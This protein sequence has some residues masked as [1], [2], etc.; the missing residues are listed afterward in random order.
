MAAICKQNLLLSGPY[1]GE[2]CLEMSKTSR[3]TTSRNEL[4][5][6][7]IE[8][9]FY[10][11]VV[12][13][14]AGELFSRDDVLEESFQSDV[15][16]SE[17]DKPRFERKF[18]RA[19]DNPVMMSGEYLWATDR[20]SYFYFHWLC[21]VLPRLEA[22]FAKG[23]RDPPPLVIPQRIVGQPFVHASLAAWP[24]ILVAPPRTER[25]SVKPEWLEAISRPAEM[26]FVHGALLRAVSRRLKTLASSSGK[27]T[28]RVYVTRVSARVRRVENEHEIIPVLQRHGFEIVEMEKLALRQQIALMGETAVLAGPHGGG[29]TNMM[30]MPTGGNVLELRKGEGPPPCFSNLAAAFGHEWLPFVCEAQ[31]DAEHPHAAHIL[32]DPEKFDDTLARLTTK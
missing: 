26:P 12:F 29:L 5:I 13:N 24:E 31:D 14:E 27:A 16:F 32:A 15:A 1:V 8:L 22:F 18:R 4:L 10:Q 17:R 6:E 11:N 2:E 20:L 19:W 7:P 23:R 30:F 3:E 9:R 25:Q 21:D 28:R